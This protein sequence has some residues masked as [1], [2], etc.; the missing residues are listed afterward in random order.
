MPAA[1]VDDHDARLH[2]RQGVGVDQVVG[3]LGQRTMQR[4]DVRPRVQVVQCHILESHLLGLRRIGEFIVGQHPHAKAVQ[5]A[6]Q[7][8][9]DLARADDARGLA[10]HIEPHQAGDV[11]IV[12]AGAIVG[13]VGFAIQRQHQGHGMLGHGVRRVG[14]HAHHMNAPVEHGPQ[15]DV[16]VA[17][18]AQRNQVNVVGRQDVGNRGRQMIVDKQAHRLIAVGNDGGVFVQMAAQ[19]F[20]FKLIR[21][22]S[23][24]KRLAVVGFGVV[25]QD[26][27]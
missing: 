27:R 23:R 3:L 22:V 8:P 9:P 5:D 12:V 10:A 24:I 17:G 25:K 26:A 18:A 13:F 16:V 19:I 15:V 11:K 7:N 2:L 20:E 4:D 6:D 1:G 14:G 21:P